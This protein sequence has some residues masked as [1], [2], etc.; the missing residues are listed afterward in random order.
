V[1]SAKVIRADEL[2]AVRR[3]EVP[4]VVTAD[5]G[6]TQNDTSVSLCGEAN[7]ADA[8]PDRA[9]PT[10]GPRRALR[11]GDDMEGSRS[12]EDM[13]VCTLF[14]KCVKLHPARTAVS[15]R[16]HLCD[17]AHLSREVDRITC[18][19]LTL[20]CEPQARIC[21]AVSHGIELVASVFAV[22]KIGATYVPVDTR[23]PVDR[24][25]Y[26][27]KDSHA[28]AIIY[29]RQH[30][31]IATN[32]GIATLCVEDLSEAEAAVPPRGG[33]PSDLAYILYTSGSTGAPKGVGITHS[34]LLNYVLWAR[35]RYI[36]STDDRI[37]LYTT[38]AFDFTVTC[39]FPPLIAGASVGIYDGIA[40][41]MAIREIIADRSVNIIKITPS[42][43]HVLSQL[44]NGQ[45]HISRLIV[46]GED[47]KV[48]L[49]AKVHSQLMQSVE[50]INEYG[51]TEATVGC[52][53]HAF[54]PVA[55]QAG[56]VPIGVPIPGVQVYVLDQDGSLIEDDREGELCVSGR[57][58]ASGYINSE[59]RSR[60]VFISNP[61][62][63]GTLLYRTG[64]V[65]RRNGN[66]DLL[67]VG[68]RDDQVKIRGNRVELSEVMA[69]MLGLPM[70]T[71]AYV[72]PVR[73][74]G[75]DTLVAVVTGHDALVERDI[76]AQLE[77]R[78]PSYMIPTSLK[79]IAE[80]P[81]TS[82][83]K[84]N[85]TAVLAILEQEE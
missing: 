7:R 47:L 19:L 34:N 8:V 65:V 50:I 66:G 33:N 11:N 26:I 21:L 63:P 71:S 30:A 41:P 9:G 10:R 12:S 32:S 18:A 45:N 67:F 74:H 72:T 38:L 69:A 57:S 37:A 83:K 82:N 16:G 4:D 43:L 84:V 64:D 75:S 3:G 28:S 79:V 15:D 23:N 77:R 85:R 56:S 60:A 70:V 25:A 62:E 6:A 78:L 22:L 1:R 53:F 68:R 73:N 14:D 13:N 17:Y 29:S 42:Y 52:V 40:D 54:D 48:A 51:P 59:A 81:M 20:G 55:D 58:V 46:G 5:A 2:E 80:L 76:V 24:I 35:D 39:I 27:I 36:Q 31:G 61:F 49:A 44:L